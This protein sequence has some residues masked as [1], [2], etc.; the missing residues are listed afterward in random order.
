MLLS[1]AKFLV[2]HWLTN[3][4]LSNPRGV[5]TK[6]LDC[7]LEVSE[8]ES[9]YYVHFRT[10]TFGKEFETLYPSRYRLN[11]IT[12]VLRHLPVTSLKSIPKN[13]R[14]TIGNN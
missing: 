11:S 2:S 10:D 13:A 7:S 8:L 5:M 12:T 9:R 1:L 14:D 6:V 4:I 3:W